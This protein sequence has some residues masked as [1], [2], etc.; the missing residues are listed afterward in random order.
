[1]FLWGGG[2]SALKLLTPYVSMEVL[3]FWRFFIMSLSFIPI[4]FY[5][6][7]ALKLNIQSIQFIIGSTLLNIS[8]MIFSYYGVSYGLAGSAS[9]IITTLSPLFTF[10]LAA[11]IGKKTIPQKQLLG[12]F[13]GF[14]G[15]AVM[16]HISSFEL[17]LESGH[18]FFLLCALV[19]A[20]VTLLAQYSHAHLHPIHYSFY[21]SLTATILSFFYALNSDLSS[22]FSQ[23]IEF[24]IALLY[25]A[26]FGQSIATTI[27]FVASGKLGSSQTSS[28]MFL[29]PVFALFIAALVL[30]ESLQVHILLGGGLSLIALYLI[31]TKS[32]KNS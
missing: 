30:D 26:I 6:K 22:V 8:F 20:G 3:V 4:L 5:L 7:Q 9:V 23:G 18:L 28:F 29:V 21:I 2:W 11:Y 25:L 12:L 10:I 15:G 16:L 13:I 19:W 27:F 1:M 17:F 32:D 14:V 24:W 31:N